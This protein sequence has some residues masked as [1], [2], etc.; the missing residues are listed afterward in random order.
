MRCDKACSEAL[1]GAAKR[2]ADDALRSIEKRKSPPK[3][4][5]V[6][7]PI[8]CSRLGEGLATEP[9]TAL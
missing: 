1:R 7:P 4:A 5:G 8:R 6:W 2:S 3:R 9:E